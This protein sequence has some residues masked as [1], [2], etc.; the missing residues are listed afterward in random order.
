MVG[1]ASPGC[2]W[3]G[4]LTSPFTKPDACRWW[5]LRSSRPFY[6]KRI[7]AAWGP[8]FGL[9]AVGHPDRFCDLFGDIRITV[10]K[11]VTILVSF[12]LMALIYY[13]IERPCLA[14]RCALRLLIGTPQ[15]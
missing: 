9:P 2:C 8:R 3:N 15:P 6:F 11:L 4:L 10:L 7:M 12:A 5:F 13:V 1:S 14:Q